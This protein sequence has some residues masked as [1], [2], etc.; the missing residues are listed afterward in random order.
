[1]MTETALL[2]N[3]LTYDAAMLGDRD[4]RSEEGV[5]LGHLASFL[6]FNLST[7]I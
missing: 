2:A 7:S 4:I 6:P 3:V 5:S 1:M